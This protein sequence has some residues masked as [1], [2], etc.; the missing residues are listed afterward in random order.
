LRAHGEI[1]HAAQAPAIKGGLLLSQEVKRYFDQ[2]VDEFD[3]IYGGKKSRPEKL[4]DWIFRK[5]MKERFSLTLLECENVK[6]K[7]VLDIGC[8]TGR[9]DVELAKRGAYV[10]GIDF[11]SKMIEYSTVLAKKNGLEEK[12]R[13]ICAD[14]IEHDFDEKFDI[15]V[16]IGFFDYVKTPAPHIGKMKLVTKEK[17]IVS[18]PAKWA[19][20][21]PIR[22]IWLKKRNCPV[23]FYDRK[24]IIDLLSSVFP[25]FDI[26]K[27]SAAYFCTGHL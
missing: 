4:L 11:S 8:G 21:M 7:T 24:S 19:F 3:S 13:F 9:I 20:Q 2:I 15:T 6:G 14:F 16:A 22:K 27:I 25:K 1:S 17:C 23:Y 18:F 10:L 26:T 5:G 12:C